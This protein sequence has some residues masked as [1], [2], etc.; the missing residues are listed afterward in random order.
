MLDPPAAR[1]RMS[2]IWI[3][4]VRSGEVERWRRWA[5]ET[6]G[7]ERAEDDAERDHDGGHLSV[8]PIEP[9]Q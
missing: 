2:R 9:C 7:E 3:V 1:W 8:L 5:Y 4:L 6:A